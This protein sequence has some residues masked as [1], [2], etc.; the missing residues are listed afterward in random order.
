EKRDGGHAERGGNVLPGPIVADERIRMRDRSDERV[1]AR[2][3]S[4]HVRAA[5]GQPF[6]IASGRKV[7]DGDASISE[8]AAEPVTLVDLVRVCAACEQHSTAALHEPLEQLGL[9]LDTRA[10]LVVAAAA[11]VDRDDRPRV[12]TKPAQCARPGRLALR[13]PQA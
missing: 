5:A 8:P 4:Q 6:E 11:E 1:D 13:Y 7:R 12:R 9:E 3:P 10:L 2:F